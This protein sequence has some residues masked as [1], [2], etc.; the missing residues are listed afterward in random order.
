MSSKIDNNMLQRVLK[1]LGLP[2]QAYSVYNYL[3]EKGPASA[4]QLAENLAIP[5]P[6][7][8]DYVHILNKA[9][10]VVENIQ[11]NK[12]V[13]SVDDVKIIPQLIEDKIESLGKE[14]K[15]LEK[16]LPELTAKTTSLEPKIR[17][18]SGVDGVK[19]VL[20]DMLWHSNIETL[21]MWP[22]TE[23]VELLG[24]EYM[25]E[26]N[27]KRI[28]N[29]ISVRGIWPK[30]KPAQLKEYPFLGVGKRHLRETRLAPKG[31][32]WNMSYWLYADKVAFIS[33]R[34]ETFG[35]VIHSRD[36]VSL[37]KSQFEV[38]WSI[39]TPVKPQPQFTNAFLDTL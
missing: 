25:A 1:E 33:S 21:T 17:V 22:V 32:D 8:Y 20:R 38:I 36:F 10:L 14:K 35:F 13:F 27:R 4:R 39:S 5:R 19:Q 28:H 3:L 24:K 16:I 15:L 26:L 23:M 29:H 18:F 7:V 2:A 9:G 37:I 12:K 6:S 34:Q 31:M 11:D 30:H